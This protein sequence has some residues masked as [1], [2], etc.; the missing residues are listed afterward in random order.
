MGAR[1]R[2]A[3]GGAPH[4]DQQVQRWSVLQ[5]CECERERG[6]PGVGWV[7]WARPEAGVLHACC[8]VAFLWWET[9]LCLQWLGA[10][11]SQ[12]R[13]A[14]TPC[15]CDPDRAGAGARLPGPTA[16][17]AALHLRAEPHC[18][19]A[20]RPAPTCT[21]PAGGCVHR[22]VQRRRSAHLSPSS[23][24]NRPLD[25]SSA[26]APAPCQHPFPAPSTPPPN[27]PSPPQPTL[28]TP[29]HPR[30]PSLPPSPPLL[31]SPPLPRAPPSEA[32]LC[33]AG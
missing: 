13:G 23:R 30:H 15:C 10:L 28:A 8:R 9:V 7:G 18:A 14:S 22:I 11:H 20:H 4:R 6:S 17:Q 29:T 5:L 25:S 33:S 26:D 27:P 24:P 31:A 1:A 2:A 32:R 21:A 16:T 3:R 19:A 12:L